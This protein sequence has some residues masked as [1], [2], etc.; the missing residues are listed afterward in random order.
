MIFRIRRLLPIV[1]VLL[2]LLT[3]VTLSVSAFSLSVTNSQV[4]PC[5]PGPGATCC[6]DYY[7]PCGACLGHCFPILN[8]QTVHQA[9]ERACWN[10]RGQL[11]SWSRSCQTNFECGVRHCG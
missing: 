4:S 10:D 3:S 8:V 9:H 2:M 7:H 11:I 6:V 5:I 1:V